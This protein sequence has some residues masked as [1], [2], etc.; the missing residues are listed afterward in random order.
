MT[1]KP[2]DHTGKALAVCPCLNCRNWRGLRDYNYPGIRGTHA[3]RRRRFTDLGGTSW[4]A[5]LYALASAGCSFWYV[6][7]TDPSSAFL[8]TAAALL[9]LAWHAR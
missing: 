5:P 4:R 9:G 7:A 8:W 3:P 2:C 6:F 1:T